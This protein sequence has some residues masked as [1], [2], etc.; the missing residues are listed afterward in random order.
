MRSTGALSAGTIAAAIGAPP[1]SRSTISVSGASTEPVLWTVTRSFTP[2]YFHIIRA[3]G[4]IGP[5][6][7][8]NP[9]A[10]QFHL[11]HRRDARIECEIERTGALEFNRA[12]LLGSFGNIIPI[13]VFPY[14]HLPCPRRHIPPGHG[15]NYPVTVQIVGEDGK[16][17][18]P[19]SRNE[20]RH[21]FTVCRF[22]EFPAYHMSGIEVSAAIRQ[23][24]RDVPAEVR[25]M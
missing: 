5:F 18:R 25:W 14:S 23:Y 7:V 1:A 3:D 10:H 9:L 12:L 4:Q 16:F 22:F 15:G 21:T 19:G 20:N 11:N 6:P 13:G 17:I 24:R 2:D 8:G